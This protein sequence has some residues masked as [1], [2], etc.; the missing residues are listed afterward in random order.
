MMIRPSVSS[1]VEI[2][3]KSG[4]HFRPMNPLSYFRCPGREISYDGC[5]SMSTRQNVENMGPTFQKTVGRL[6][7]VRNKGRHV[8]LKNRRP[9]EEWIFQVEICPGRWKLLSI[10]FPKW[11]HHFSKKVKFLRGWLGEDYDPNYLSDPKTLI[12]RTAELEIRTSVDSDNIMSKTVM[13]ARHT[14]KPVKSPGK[15][16]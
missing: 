10:Y 4:C 16:R 11:N 8:I 13:E 7:D 6:Y 5:N 12:G 14:T 9:L 3:A 2:L 15:N 1:V